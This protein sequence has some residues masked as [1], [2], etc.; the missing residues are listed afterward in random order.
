MFGT[1][2]FSELIIILVIVLIIFGAGRLPQI[3][4]GVGKALKGFKKEVNE[5]P[6]PT[7]DQVEQKTDQS[8]AIRT[9]TPIAVPPAPI[10]GSSSVTISKP[11][12]P[13]APGPELTPGTTASL[14]YNTSPQVPQTSASSPDHAATPAP[15]Q[16]LSM[17]ERAIDPPPRAHAS[18][19]PLPAGSRAKPT[20]KRPSAIVNKDAV[21]RI[22]AQQAALKA[23]SPQS[24]AAVSP[25][26]LQHL[27]EGL[28]EVVRT[29]RQAVTDVRHSVD[30]Q[31]STIQAEMDAAKKEIQQSIEA[32][33]E[34]PLVQ[35]DSQ[36][37]A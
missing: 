23:K 20:A 26:D 16:V 25:D 10:A 24:A 21:A 8:Q 28:G 36:K 14:L 7:S 19:P 18:Y 22:Q 33:K 11:N 5:A 30:P 13:Y 17:E 34:S 32:A 35:E 27:G 6:Q 37:S 4:E 29:F 3:G 1:M 2:G 15:N 12:V 31:M 9:Q